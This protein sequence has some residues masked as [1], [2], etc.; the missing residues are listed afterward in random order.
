MAGDVEVTYAGEIIK[1]KGKNPRPSYQHQIE[2]KQNLD[3]MNKL[4][5]FSTLLVLPT[6]GG[7]TYTAATWLLR[8]AINEHK[9]VMWIAHRQML[10]EQALE[11]FKDYPYEEYIPKISGFNFRIISGNKNH[12]R[13]INIKETDDILF[14]SKDS[15]G[16]NL[17]KLNKWIKN[18]SEIYLIIDEAH[19]STARTYQKIINY[20][21]E[22][23][24]NV[25]II[26]LTAT[27]MRTAKRE[28]GKLAEIFCDGIDKKTKK[29]IQGKFEE[30]NNKKTGICYQIA[31]KDLM[32]NVILSGTV[33]NFTDMT[34]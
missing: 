13:M 28:Q 4:D 23:V 15:A 34:L 10:I 14:V 7:K 29:V 3:K 24:E 2:A 8:N 32:K 26:G 21:Y 16:R 5:S 33:H 9:K 19:H 22:N 25:K 31:L 20:F 27:P 6:G 17:E 12:D 18:E 1:T 30:N 11:T